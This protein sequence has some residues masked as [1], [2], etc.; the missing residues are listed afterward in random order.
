MIWLA[1]KLSN[2]RSFYQSYLKEGSALWEKF[3]QKDAKKQEWF[4]RTVL[5]L[6]KELKDFPAWQ[7]YDRLVNIVFGGGE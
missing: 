2:M 7:E 4:Y 3:N 1:D 5:D 6:T